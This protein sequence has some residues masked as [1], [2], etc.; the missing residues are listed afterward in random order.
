MSK[1]MSE[2]KPIE[3]SEICQ[4]RTSERM[5]ERMPEDMSEKEFKNIL[6]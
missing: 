4:N 6:I 2:E 3:M 1:D 5:P